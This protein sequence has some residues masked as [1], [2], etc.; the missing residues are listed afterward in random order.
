[1][2][3]WSKLEPY[4]GTQYRSFEELCYQIAK[5]L[6]E[7]EGRFTSIDDSGG[8][9]GVEFYLTFPDGR[10]WGWQAKFYYPNGR[11]SV[12]NRKTSIEKSLQKACEEHPQ[13][14]KWFL[15]LPTNLSPGDQKWFDSKLANSTVNRRPTVPDGH[16]VQ[17]EQWGESNIIGWM[18]EER[19]AGMKH[20]FF[21]ELELT[22]AWFRRQF[23]KQIS[24]LQDKYE[25]SLHT[26]THDEQLVHALLGDERFAEELERRLGVLR[27]DLA[28]YD[29]KM[30]EL[31]EEEPNNIEY[32]DRRE[33]LIEASDVLRQ[34]LVDLVDRLSEIKENVR[35]GELASA[36]N[37]VRTLSLEPVLEKIE[38]YRALKDEIDVSTL[39]F[40]GDP[41]QEEDFKFRIDRTLAAPASYAAR[42]HDGAHQ[43]IFLLRYLERPD[44][45]ALGDAGDGKTH[46]ACRICDD[47]IS[48]GLP[49]IF[50][51][52]RNF[53]GDG[54]L[55]GQLRDLLDIPPSYGWGDFVQALDAAALAH[56]T[57]IPLVI[58]GLNEATRNGQFSRVW[59]RH[60]P[61]FVE[62]LSRTPNVALI[63]TSRISYRDAIWREK[64]MPENVMFVDGFGWDEVEEAIDKYFAA[65]RIRAD[66]ASAPLE[67]FEHPIYL[68]LF[69]EAK[70]PERHEWVDVHVGEE[71]LFEVFDQYVDRCDAEVARLMGFR[72]G[73]R[74]VGRSLEKVATYLWEH[75]TRFVP[76][77]D[78][79]KLIDGEELEQLDWLSS[80]TYAMESEG[81]LVCREWHGQGE[82]YFF[83]YDLMA[84][85]LI[86]RHLLEECDDL[87]EF[88]NSDRTVTLLYAD[89]IRTRHPLYED[90]RRALAALAPKLAG[91]HVHEF[92]RNK[93]AVADSVRALFEIM[94]QYIGESSLRLVTECFGKEANRRALLNLSFSTMARAEHPLNANYW[95]ERL[96]LLSLADR[97]LSW[98]EHV[99]RTQGHVGTLV[100]LLEESCRSSVEYEAEVA[101]RLHLLAKHSM[102]VLTSTVN[103]LRDKDTRA[104][105]WYGR[106]FPDEF[107]ALVREALEVDDPNV[108]ER[109]LAACYGVAMARRYDPADRD[110]VQGTLPRWAEELYTAMFAPGA[111]HA[112]THILARN[113][114]RRT[115]EIASIHHPD[116]LHEEHLERTKPPYEEGGIREWGESEDKN[117]GEYREGNI[118]ISILED[119]PMGQLGPGIS[120]YQSGT[121][122]YK[123][124]KA[125]LW[126]RIYDLGYSFDRFGA[127]DAQIHREV[128]YSLYSR[129][130]DDDR[131]WAE[132]Y[133]RK[134]ARIATRELAGYRDDLGLL[135]NEYDCEINP[136][137]VDL[138]PSFPEKLPAL[139]LITGDLLGDR[140][141]P[142]GEWI[143]CGPD[144]TFDEVLEIEEI[145][146]ER[147]PWVLLYGHVTQHDE[148]SRRYMFCFMQ[149]V[150]LS[151]ADAEE[152]LD[153][154]AGAEESRL[155]TTDIPE[156]HYTYAGEIPWCETYPPNEPSQISL[157]MGDNTVTRNS[158]GVEFIRNGERISDA[159]YS[160]LMSR[161]FDHE[162]AGSKPE[163]AQAKITDLKSALEAEGIEVVAEEVTV[164][165]QRPDIVYF[166]MTMPVNRHSWAGR[167]IDITPGFAAYVPARQIADR[168]A[169]TNRPQTYDLFDP[170]G[171]RASIAFEYGDKFS[172]R[173]EFAYIR[174]DLWDRYLEESGQRLAWALYGE[175]AL[176][177]AARGGVDE[178]LGGSSPYV[179]YRKTR[180]Y[181]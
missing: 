109:M 18:R 71:A 85:Y 62:E 160:E 119:D 15:C 26:E 65:Y 179:R 88:L 20:Y 51:P 8:G 147:G 164:E 162:S 99:R 144:L 96:K 157:I 7:H 24:G 40:S 17:L 118:P 110:F 100:G 55:E 12:S 32:G 4:G 58:D 128:L 21:G 161:C 92:T 76:V 113:Y 59:E 19:F 77:S 95:H 140:C 16:G 143:A 155:D 60:L 83:T 23:E 116:M 176:Y 178:L 106:R 107:F 101:E 177:H 129:R 1:M 61:G 10:Q 42:I 25:R 2:V 36:R 117:E 124:A 82:E 44:L 53:T 136:P 94:P 135:K 108:S 66:L 130:Y 154:L 153:V 142:L 69:C 86:A 50:L 28:V 180:L 105:Y 148:R 120:K 74:V 171:Q 37:S 111:P 6:Y 138:D 134:Y 156:N 175:R 169:L 78:A 141:Q 123:E 163:N 151:A 3:D 158:D 14:E 170:E 41:D 27:E 139:Q 132:G 115:I 33:P 173:Q 104:L 5:G 54:S 166:E 97:D 174:K 127:V 152:I 75:E 84:G 167:H 35:R 137:H 11:L 159:E 168:L 38:A 145:Q 91:R 73:A 48:N 150:L 98:S 146:G 126:W 149:G 57:R 79:A 22:P 87:T 172:N 68:K 102:W 34:G 70:N 103:A 45:H 133:G 49:T 64:G 39:P 89:D 90:I 131:S 31:N 93:R 63:T 13:L 56:R 181:D 122:E 47:R 67:Q 114:A 125:N 30:Q 80:R 112:T 9:D 46:L 72:R 52:G 165:D 29:D 81:L 43:M 121:S